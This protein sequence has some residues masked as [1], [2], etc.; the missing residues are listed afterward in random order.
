MG[1]GSKYD[2]VVLEVQH[3]CDINLVFEMMFFA[4]HSLICRKMMTSFSHKSLG[5]YFSVKI[6]NTIFPSP[7]DYIR[8]FFAQKPILVLTQTLPLA[9]GI[10]LQLLFHIFHK[11]KSLHLEKS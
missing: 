7:S 11:N 10:L 8:F 5:L 9:E 2:V 1:E 3:F 4:W 6:R